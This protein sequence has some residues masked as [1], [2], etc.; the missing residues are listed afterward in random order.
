MTEQIRG[1][2]LRDLPKQDSEARRMV[3]AADSRRLVARLIST[4]QPISRLQL[5]MAGVRLNLA[6]VGYQIHPNMELDYIVPIEA[7]K[8]KQQLIDEM[9]DVLSKYPLAARNIPRRLYWQVRHNGR[10]VRRMARRKMVQ[11]LEGQEPN[12]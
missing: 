10:L 4:R 9:M 11:I 7:P 12:E 8:T 3:I 5:Y 6:R 2:A 1:K